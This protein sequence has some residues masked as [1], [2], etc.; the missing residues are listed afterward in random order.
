[1]STELDGLKSE[2]NEQNNFM[3]PSLKEMVEMLE[4]DNQSKDEEI[5]LIKA[6]LQKKDQEIASLKIKLVGMDSNNSQMDHNQNQIEQ[7]QSQIAVLQQQ[8][9]ELKNQI[10]DKNL[11]IEVLKHDHQEELKNLITQKQEIPD[12]NQTDGEIEKLQNIISQ[13]QQDKSELTIQ[14]Y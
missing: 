9:S 4:S 2:V 8:L 12:N 3:I 1:M 13:L 10:D 6:N 5:K 11:E 14:Y 7:F